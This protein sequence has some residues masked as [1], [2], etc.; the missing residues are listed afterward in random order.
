MSSL[1][2]CPSRAPL[3]SSLLVP[4]P[5]LICITLTLFPQPYPRLPTLKCSAWS[6]YSVLG[7][8]IYCCWVNVLISLTLGIKPSLCL[9]LT[10]SL[11]SPF[12]LSLLWVNLD[13]FLFTANE[14]ARKQKRMM[15][16]VTRVEMESQQG[17]PRYTIYL[18]I[19]SFYRHFFHFFFW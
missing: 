3:T 18:Q 10:V 9:L 7:S 11:Q 1:S 13:P 15:L 6:F 19:S 14:R 12:W 16:T 5:L 17:R 8:L 2:R 4:P